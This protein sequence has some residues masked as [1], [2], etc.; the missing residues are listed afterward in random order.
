MNR[1]ISLVISISR[2]HYYYSDDANAEL[3]FTGALALPLLLLYTNSRVLCSRLWHG[4]FHYLLVY[5][6][7]YTDGGNVPVDFG[8]IWPST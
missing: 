7:V 4:Q 2:H 8:I 6:A 3:I 1:L 5:I